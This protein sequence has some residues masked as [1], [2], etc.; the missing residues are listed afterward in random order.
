MPF[1]N[2]WERATFQV[3]TC[4]LLC[5]RRSSTSNGRGYGGRVLSDVWLLDGSWSEVL[6]AHI[7]G[8]HIYTKKISAQVI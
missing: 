3:E 2:Y 7:H 1:L 6:Y 4:C 8:V 5:F